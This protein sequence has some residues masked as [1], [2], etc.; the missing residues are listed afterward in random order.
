MLEGRMENNMIVNF[1]GKREY[2]GK[3]VELRIEKAMS[4]YLTGKIINDNTR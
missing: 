3:I 4:F 1:E 2:I